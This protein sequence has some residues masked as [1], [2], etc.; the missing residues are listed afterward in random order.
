MPALTT[1]IEGERDATGNELPTGVTDEGGATSALAGQPDSSVA[2]VQLAILRAELRDVRAQRDALREQV[3]ALERSAPDRGD[4]DPAATGGG[5][6]ARSDR[7][8]IIQRY[9][10]IIAE[11]DDALERARSSSTGSTDGAAGVSTVVAALRDLVSP[12]R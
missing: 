5:T 2:A 8:A 10:R 6:E 7:Q 1:S 9:E 3:A 12:T 11:K 4:G